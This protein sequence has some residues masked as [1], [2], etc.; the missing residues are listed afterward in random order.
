MFYY[1]VTETWALIRPLNTP[2]WAQSSWSCLREQLVHLKIAVETR[3]AVHEVEVEP[4]MALVG[5][6][7]EKLEKKVANSALALPYDLYLK[8]MLLQLLLVDCC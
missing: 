6:L 5:A 8:M 2:I 7:L 1:E 4:E 3:V